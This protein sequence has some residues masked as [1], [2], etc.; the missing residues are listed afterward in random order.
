[1]IIRRRLTLT[2]AVVLLA[3]CQAT[4][5]GTP[6]ATTRIGTEVPRT[7]KA[8][9]DDP[10]N[11]H[12]A[13]VGDRTGGHRP[14]VFEHA[15]QQINWMQPEFV[16]NVGDLVEG[17][18]HDEAQMN[19]EWQ[20]VNGMIDS[21]QMPF[22][23]V[24]GNHDLSNDAMAQFWRTH[25]GADY[26]HFVYKNVLFLALNTEDPPN[27][28]QRKKAMLGID[29]AILERAIAALRAGPE[30]T[31]SAAADP[32]VAKAIAVMTSDQVTISAAQV[33]QVRQALAANTDVRWTVVL[34]HKPAWRYP[35]TE[36]EQIEALLAKRPYT[37]FAG[38]F[39]YYQH[40]QRNG[41]DYIQLGTTGGVRGQHTSGPGDLDHIAWVTMTAQGPKI[42]NI[43]L[44]HL[45]DRRGPQSVTAPMH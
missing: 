27:A 2:L 3:A 41:R 11:F 22:F 19:K 20:E 9:L 4:A 29:P 17:Y 34:M 10:D 23:Y 26:Y 5:P 38:H 21:L 1:M 37:V 13:I 25:L 16:I 14:G 42:A 7:D 33:E 35:S 36:F 6:A 28:E 39:H 31:R 8:F 44:Q 15:M 12:F 18:T 30:Q 32:Q 24:V 43:N 40:E 45:H